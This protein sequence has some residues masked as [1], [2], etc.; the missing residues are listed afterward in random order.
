MSQLWAK[1][2]VLPSKMKVYFS[3]VRSTRLNRTPGGR[4]YLTFGGPSLNKEG[5]DEI[6]GRPGLQEMVIREEPNISTF[7][8][9]ATSVAAQPDGSACEA[10]LA[11][12]V[13]RCAIVI[14]PIGFDEGP[15]SPK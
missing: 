8:Q 1:V 5:I 9:I 3:S 7:Q 12:A 10:I 11:S 14:R 2:L 13:V 6:S 15:T 4:E